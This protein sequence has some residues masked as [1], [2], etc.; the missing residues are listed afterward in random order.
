MNTKSY[1]DKLKYGLL[2][3]EYIYYNEFLSKKCVNQYKINIEN[4]INKQLKQIRKLKKNETY[5]PYEYDKLQLEH[6]IQLFN[7]IKIFN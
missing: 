2:S 7:Y 3:Q 5:K 1:S 4:E 6:S